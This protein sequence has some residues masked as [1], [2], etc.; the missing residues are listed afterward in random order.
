MADEMTQR[1]KP[2]RT[3]VEL[4]DLNILVRK[5]GD[6]FAVQTFT[7]AEHA[8]AERYATEIGGEIVD[9]SWPKKAI[10]VDQSVS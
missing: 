3:D 2:R 4:R 9:I 10:E 1:I 6:P 7:D 5:D 8:D